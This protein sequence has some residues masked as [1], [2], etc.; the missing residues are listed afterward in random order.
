MAAI[1]VT[2]FGLG[3]RPG[4]LDRAKADPRAYLKSQISRHAGPQP[5]G[6]LMDAPT[7][8]VTWRTYQ[9]ANRGVQQSPAER[10]ERASALG[11]QD[12]LLARAQLAARTEARSARSAGDC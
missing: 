7:R 5:A 1:A 8:Y 4:E 10:A 2:R 6:E 9:Q 12:E 3:A 11:L